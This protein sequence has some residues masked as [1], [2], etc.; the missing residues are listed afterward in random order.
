[1]KCLQQRNAN[2]IGNMNGGNT[3][4]PKSIEQQSVTP[5]DSRMDTPLR[6]MSQTT[7]TD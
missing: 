3:T 1:M 7:S 6:N 4:K 5:L 2:D